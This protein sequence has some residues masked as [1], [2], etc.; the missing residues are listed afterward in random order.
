M[1]RAYVHYGTPEQEALETV[2][3]SQM[4]AYAAGGHFKAGSMGPKVEAC[5]SFVDAGGES[6]IASLTEVGPALAGRAGTHIVPDAAA[7]R[8][9]GAGR[10]VEGHAAAKPKARPRGP[11]AAAKKTAAP[12]AGPQAA[13]E[14]LREDVAEVIDIGH[15]PAA[16]G[17]GVTPSPATGVRSVA[18]AGV[19][20]LSGPAA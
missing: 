18:Q 3:A 2:T 15:R 5:L 17:P 8:K 7:K 4:R 10:E 1:P 14:H 19:C 13:Q 12:K 11:G 16:S 6:V 20:R 9:A